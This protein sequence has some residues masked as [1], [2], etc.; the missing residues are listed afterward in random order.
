MRQR[1][2]AYVLKSRDQKSKN[3]VVGCLKKIVCR[4]V[5]LLR[6]GAILVPVGVGV[7]QLWRPTGAMSLR[8][9]HGREKERP[10]RQGRLKGPSF[11]PLVCAIAFLLVLPPAVLA[12]FFRSPVFEFA[13]I[14]FFLG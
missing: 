10:P 1:E 12:I 8:D 9:Q 7:A 11:F 6:S 4:F 13:G 14:L 5:A 3:Q 2:P